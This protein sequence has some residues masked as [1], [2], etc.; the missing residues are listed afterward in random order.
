MKMLIVGPSLH[1]I[2]GISNFLFG[3]MSFLNKTNINNEYFDTYS[4]KNRSK[5]GVSTFSIFEFFLAL[6]VFVVFSKRLYREKFGSVVLNTSSYWGFYEKSL[7]LIISKVFKVKTVLIVHGADFELF[8]S[9]SSARFFIRWVLNS[10]D[11]TIFV[12]KEHFDYFC[13]E[14][15]DSKLYHMNVPVAN[16]VDVVDFLET[17]SVNNYTNKYEKVYLTLSV[18]EPR[19]NVSSIVKAFADARLKGSCLLVAGDG[20]ERSGIESLCEQHENIMYL[21]AARG[22]FKDYLL[23]RSNFM[24]CF[25]DRES[26]GITFIESML[27]ECILITPRTGVLESFC[28]DESFILVKE[29]SVSSLTEAIEESASLTADECCELKRVASSNSKSFTWETIGPELVAILT[30]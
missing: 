15:N 24:I 23:S 21:G 30:N 5:Q 12:S 25:S 13:G 17:D 18:L 29:H 3:L 20:P 16:K 9:N 14:L 26:Y 8:Y 19:K 4:V 11:K 22:Q 27:S 7:L 28:S 10:A 2:G 1:V 6:N